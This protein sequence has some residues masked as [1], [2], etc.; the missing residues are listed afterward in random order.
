MYFPCTKKSTASFSNLYI[1][2]LYC[3]KPNFQCSEPE[4]ADSHGECTATIATHDFSSSQAT[5]LICCIPHLLRVCFGH[6]APGETKRQAKI[7]RLIRIDRHSQNS[8][9]QSVWLKCAIKFIFWGGNEVE[10]ATTNLSH[11]WKVS[12]EDQNAILTSGPW[13]LI[14]K[15]FKIS[16]KTSAIQFLGQASGHGEDYE[17]LIFS[18]RPDT[19]SAGCQEQHRI[20]PVNAWPRH[21]PK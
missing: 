19:S 9:V 2:V 10:E 13:K 15:G 3:S 1:V 6:G 16:W 5:S 12:H 21:L 18:P 11:P 7:D 17:D 14:Q 20:H 8:R 4:N